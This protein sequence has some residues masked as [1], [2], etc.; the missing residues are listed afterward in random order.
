MDLDKVLALFAA[1]GRERVDYVLVGEISLNVRGLVRAT[2]DLDFFVW[3]DV[4][5]TARLRAALRSV[6]NDA[7]IEQIRAENLSGGYPVVR[8]SPPGEDSVVD[9][10]V[11]LSTAF[12]FDDLQ[13]DTLQLGGVAV[14][15]ATPRTLY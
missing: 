13:F 15:V 9:I 11:H 2:E 6:W 12:G 5:T 10:M 14:R 7:E 3:P 1:L 8:F 4:A